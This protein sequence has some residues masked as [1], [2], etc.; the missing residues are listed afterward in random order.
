MQSRHLFSLPRRV[1]VSRGVGGRPR[2]W[3]VGVAQ[4]PTGA[5]LRMVRAVVAPCRLQSTSTNRNDHQPSTSS[6]LQEH[7]HHQQEEKLRRHI[8]DRI[9]RVNQ[10][11]CLNGSPF[12]KKMEQ[13]E[14]YNG[15]RSLPLLG[16]AGE[17]G[18]Q[19]IYA[20]QL[21]VLK[22]TPDEPILQVGTSPLF[23]SSS[24]SSCCYCLCSSS[25]EQAGHGEA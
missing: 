25:S 23:S 21:Y 24:S 4:Q 2:S 22:G 17:L 3:F 11:P 9:I 8:Y 18:A 1:V 10:V 20:G 12:Y 16:K 6:S 19:Q 14:Q 7:Q 13:Q 5:G 15:A